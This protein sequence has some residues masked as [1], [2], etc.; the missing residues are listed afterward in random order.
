MPITA[1]YRINGNEVLKISLTGQSFGDRDTAYYGVLIDPILLNGNQVREFV[2]GSY[3]PMRVLG[4]AQI[5]VPG[6]NTCR[7]AAQPE[8]D[9][10]AAAETADT[11][12]M[13][14]ADAIQCFETHPRFRKAFKAFLKRV[15]AE[16]NLQAAQWNTFRAQVALASNLAD[17]K[18]R[19]AANTTDMP[20]RTIAEALIA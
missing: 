3:G 4:F 15:I 16:N 7:L 5:A 2:A 1:L 12:A 20:V 13:D 19:V 18:T 8:I 10:F 9:P 17:F 14:A 6:I 11:N